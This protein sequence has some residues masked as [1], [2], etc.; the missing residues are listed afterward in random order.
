MPANGALAAETDHA[1]SPLVEF[2]RSDRPYPKLVWDSARPAENRAA[3]E[4]ALRGER[5]V[6][7]ECYIEALEAAERAIRLDPDY[8][9]AH[10]VRGAAL[11][12]ASR[13]AE[14]IEAVDHAR[15]L[16]PNAAAVHFYRGV[17]FQYQRRYAEAIEAVARAAKIDP[18]YDGPACAIRSS[19]LNSQGC[20]AEALEATDR[21]ISLDANSSRNYIL[22]ARALDGLGRFAEEIEAAD[23]AISL[24]GDA[25]A[26]AALAKVPL[27]VHERANLPDGITVAHLMVAEAHLIRGTA[28]RKIGRYGEAIEAFGTTLEIARTGEI[29]AA[30]AV[31]LKEYY[32]NIMGKAS[33][34]AVAALSVTDLKKWIARGEAAKAELEAREATDRAAAA[35]RPDWI[36]ARKQPGKV[37]DLLAEFIRAKF[38]DELGDGT[39][40]TDKLYRYKSLYQ[41][42]QDHRRE[43]P[44]DLRSIPTKSKAN[45]RLVAE[46]KVVRP[47]RPPAARSQEVRDYERTLK[48]VVAAKRRGMCR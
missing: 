22:R 37:A 40:S 1:I 36:E 32:R 38:A 34:F 43:L 33:D 27:P 39:M 48:Q 12:G 46:G 18:S 16:D 25:T 21:A 7:E 20:F 29:V 31:Q 35:P 3:V 45:D 15:S 44:P 28:L 5:L 10:L 8:A 2:A 14:G 23:R 30:V 41:A 11:V 9:A 24:L 26:F 6:G 4:Y 47:V 19:A 17:L 13:L 42:F